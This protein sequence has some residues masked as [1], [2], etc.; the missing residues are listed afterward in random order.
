MEVALS[1]GRIDRHRTIFWWVAI[2]FVLQTWPAHAES[3][4]IVSLNPSLTAIL[5]ALGASDRLVGVDEYSAQEI[6]AVASLPQVG[7]LFNPSLEAVLELQP[8]LVIL[9]PSA[10]QRDFRSRLSELGVRVESF[11]NVRFDQVLENIERLGVLAGRRGAA[12]RRIEEISRVREAARSVSRG[13]SE[14][15][16]LMVLQRD[17]L[18]VVGK[19]SFIEDMLTQLGAVNSAAVFDEPYPRVSREWLVANGP[20]VLIDLSADATDPVAYWS[21]WPSIPA[22]AAG[23]VLRLDPGLVGMPGP[24]LDR[25]TLLLAGGLYGP[26]AKAQIKAKSQP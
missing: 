12:A 23:R 5:T 25:A 7:G 16:V 18:Y 26:D 21:R 24:Y 15:K 2:W 17:P 22:V 3:G 8:D 9:V 14:Q 10:E 11:E 6:E 1:F 19:G 20:D 4:R 13:R